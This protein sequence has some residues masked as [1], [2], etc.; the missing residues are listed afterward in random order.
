MVIMALDLFSGT[1]S[2]CNAARA[3]GISAIS[4][5]RDMDANL[6]MDIMD[7]EYRNYPP[8]YFDFI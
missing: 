8:T 2:V 4:L 7:F 6:K 3:R 1:G 5:D